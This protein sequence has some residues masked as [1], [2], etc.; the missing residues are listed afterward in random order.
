MLPAGEGPRA[1]VEG[2]GEFTLGGIA[3][4]DNGRGDTEAGREEEDTEEATAGFEGDAAELV[5]TRLPSSR[6]LR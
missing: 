5:V 2:R 1:A 4:G 6:L 3:E